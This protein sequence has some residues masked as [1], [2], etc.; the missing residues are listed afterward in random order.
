MIRPFSRQC[1][2]YEGNSARRTIFPLDAPSY[3]SQLPPYFAHA[4]NEASRERAAH[5]LTLAEMLKMSVVGGMF[6]PA[7]FLARS[8]KWNTP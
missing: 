4:T 3:V 7:V 1:T 8:R 5:S 2:N 6:Q